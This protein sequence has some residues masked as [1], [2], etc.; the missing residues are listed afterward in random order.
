MLIDI[1][2]IIK[3]TIL[4]YNLINLIKLLTIKYYYLL[5]YTYI[6]LYYSYINLVYL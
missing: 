5:I 6:I 3:S 2:H 4:Y 1:N